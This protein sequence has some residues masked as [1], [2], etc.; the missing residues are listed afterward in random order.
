[1]SYKL[2]I[3]IL[4]YDDCKNSYTFEEQRK[5]EADL[6]LRTN[7]SFNKIGNKAIKIIDHINAH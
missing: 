2:L 7:N 3:E 5:F 4:C 1:M 6:R